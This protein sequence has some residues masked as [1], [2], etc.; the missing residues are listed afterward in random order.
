MAHAYKDYRTSLAVA[1]T[2]Q[3]LAVDCHACESLNAAAEKII[4]LSGKFTASQFFGCFGNSQQ[5]MLPLRERPLFTQH[6]GLENSFY[7]S[8]Y[9]W[10]D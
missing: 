9:S 1:I 10:I 4:F 7:A 8:N 3:E 5:M 6:M 2:L